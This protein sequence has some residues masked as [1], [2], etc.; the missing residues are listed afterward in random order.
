MKYYLVIL[1]F[2]FVSI[3]S[4]QNSVNNYLVSDINRID[5]IQITLP[6]LNTLAKEYGQTAKFSQLLVQK[7]GDHYVLLAKDLAQKWIYEFELYNVDSKLYI[8]LNKH[9][10]AC[11]S[12]NL[13]L[14]IFNIVD[15]QINGCIKVNQTVLGRN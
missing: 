2:I 15:G 1:S 10:F 4:G 5:E 12:D 7:V 6:V 8:D 3:V 14:S 11:E 13:S 9:I